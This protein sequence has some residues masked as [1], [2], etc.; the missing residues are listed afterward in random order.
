MDGGRVDQFTGCLSTLRHSIVTIGGEVSARQR[1]TGWT[2]EHHSQ[3]GTDDEHR[4]SNV[5]CCTRCSL[6]IDRSSRQLCGDPKHIEL[7]DYPIGDASPSE[8]ASRLDLD[9]TVCVHID[10]W[11]AGIALGIAVSGCTSSGDS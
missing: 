8:I 5:G 11:A 7:C 9:R 6:E 4:V 2:L 1:P 10:V 3:C